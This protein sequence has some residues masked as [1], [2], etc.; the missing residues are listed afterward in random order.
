VAA[1]DA[2]RQRIE[3]D[4]HDGAQQ[5][6]VSLGLQLR[7][8]QAAVPPG[9]GELSRRLDEVADRLTSLA[10]ELREYARGIH[11]AILTE[12]GP[13]AALKALARRSPIPVDLD[14]RIRGRLPEPR[15]VC[16]YYVISEALTNAA[17]HSGASAIAVQVVATDDTLSVQVR[18]NG[19]GGASLDTGS[20]LV[21]LKDRVDAL[22][23][24]FTLHSR[25]GQGTS[26]RSQPPLGR[27][28]DTG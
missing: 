8:A 5:R 1:A 19:V 28:S 27:K 6:L 3:R 4:L 14:V 26:V 22:G 23:G 9:A 13:G 11:P 18:D 10:D 12:G 25:P 21:G 2:T 16:T 20:G 24:Q 15:E 7:T 17:K